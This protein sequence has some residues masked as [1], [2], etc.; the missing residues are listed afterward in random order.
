MVFFTIVVAATTFCP[1]RD[2]A[3]LK[4]IEEKLPDEAHVVNNVIELLISFCV[5]VL[6]CV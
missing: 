5:F 1:P 6:A 4:R 2:V 3:A